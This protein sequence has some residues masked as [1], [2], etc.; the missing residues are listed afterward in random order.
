MNKIVMLIITFFA[1]VLLLC[2]CDVT[3]EYRATE[4]GAIS[5]NTIQTIDKGDT[6]EGVSAIADEGYYFV[7][8]DDGVT[9]PER[10]DIASD[11]RTITA[12]FESDG[13]VRVTYK[14]TEGGSIS[15]TLS[16][17]VPIGEPLEPVE[18]IASNGYRFVCWSDGVTTPIRNEIATNG[19]EIE[20]IFIKLHTVTFSCDS[21]RG[22]LKGSLSQ[23]LDDGA[24]SEI[25]T[26]EAK[27]GFGFV[28]WSNGETDPTISISA[29]KD[30]E[31][32][33]IF[34]P[35]VY[36]LPIISINTEGRTPI[37]SKD[38]YVSCTF[39]LDNAG[40]QKIIN[41]GAQIKGRGNSSW[42][43]PKKPYTIKLDHPVSLFGFGKARDWTLIANCFDKSLVRNLL[44]YSVALEFAALSETSRSALVEFYLN[45]EYLGVY[46]L[47][48]KIESGKTQVNI[49]ENNTKVDTGYLV[50]LDFRR[51]GECVDVL[52]C[53]HVIKAPS[54]VTEEQKAFIADYLRRALLAIKT[55]TYEQVCELV[56]VESFAQAY[57]VFELFKCA[58]VGYT[59]FYMHKDTGGKLECGPVWD[60]DISMG[61]IDYNDDAKRYDYLWAREANPWFRLLFT[62]EEF[63]E[64]VCDTLLE[65]KSIIEQRLLEC[66]DEIYEYGQSFDRNFEKWQILGSYVWPNPPEIVEIKTWQGQ[67][68]YTREYLKNSL[69][70]LLEQY[71]YN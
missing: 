64:L 17:R 45:D 5:G 67:V 32:E 38:T 52:D 42:L 26:A 70:Y 6:L 10:Q 9:T 16:Q 51:D 54:P 61:N 1:L 36:N 65:Y 25:V 68:E 15:G 11:N 2:S 57:I 62:H 46:L 43:A 66:Y 24:K 33:A 23:V 19:V 63:Y 71:K 13:T 39:S 49:S 40:G 28:G 4:G 47:C 50:E 21:D 20:A 69:N 59:S 58:D 48:E 14:A 44:A 35:T 29:T 22:V 53:P 27:I 12:I 60:F 37:T 41:L 7:K 30:E 34:E 18:A 8:W 55:G 3:V 31:L 56:D